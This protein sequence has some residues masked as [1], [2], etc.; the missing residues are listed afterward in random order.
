[1]DDFPIPETV[2]GVCCGRRRSVGRP[3]ARWEHAASRDAVELVQTRTWKAAAR[4]V[5]GWRR[6][7]G[8]AMTQTTDRSAIKEEEEKEEESFIQ[9]LGYCLKIGHDFLLRDLRSQ[10]F[11]YPIYLTYIPEEASLSKSTGNN[12]NNWN[13]QNKPVYLAYSI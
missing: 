3:R 6:V 11:Y 8:E 10:L 4:K 9:M 5:E 7:I 1:M 2:M 13:R 12:F